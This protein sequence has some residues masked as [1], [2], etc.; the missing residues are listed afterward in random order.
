MAGRIHRTAPRTASVGR[1]PEWLTYPPEHSRAPHSPQT[2]GAS[3]WKQALLQGTSLALHTSKASP[4]WPSSAKYLCVYKL[5][6]P[7]S[8]RD[9]SSSPSRDGKS[10]EAFHW[11]CWGRCWKCW[12]KWDRQGLKRQHVLDTLLS[13]G[14]ATAL[15]WTSAARIWLPV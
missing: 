10:P 9:S 4:V 5:L 3:F 2:P 6:L 12:T 7:Q 11:A 8:R 13:D 14:T 15:P 1:S